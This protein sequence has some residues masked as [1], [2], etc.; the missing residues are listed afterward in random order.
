MRYGHY[1]ILVPHGWMCMGALLAGV[2]CYCRR[3]IET[4]SKAIEYDFTPAQPYYVFYAMQCH[5][6]LE[7]QFGNKGKNI[8]FWPSNVEEVNVSFHRPTGVVQPLDLSQCT[9][10]TIKAS[11]VFI[12]WFRYSKYSV[13]VVHSALD[14]TYSVLDLKWSVDHLSNN[15]DDCLTAMFSTDMFRRSDRYVFN[16]AESEIQSKY[17]LRSVNFTEGNVISEVEKVTGMPIPNLVATLFKGTAPKIRIPL[18]TASFLYRQ[19]SIEGLPMEKGPETQF[20]TQS[21][22]IRPIAMMWERVYNFDKLTAYNVRCEVAAQTLKIKPMSSGEI[23]VVEDDGTE[24][25]LRISGHIFWYFIAQYYKI[26]AINLDSIMSTIRY[27]A[28]MQYSSRK[29]KRYLKLKDQGLIAEVMINDADTHLWHTYQ[30]WVL[31]IETAYYVVNKR[32]PSPRLDEQR[33]LYLKNFELVKG[34]L[35]RASSKVSVLGD[36]SLD[37]VNWR[38]SK[39]NRSLL[40]SSQDK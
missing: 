40:N 5:Y 18:D 21:D 36:V 15:S 32:E 24:Y 9:S 19:C 14:A 13:F 7:D 11:R 38:P 8:A 23:L 28:T 25:P 26:V 17:N 10:A 30:E 16:Y 31:G 3:G 29:M 1:E 33:L 39:D 20:N 12:P 34:L 27:N 6:Q 2:V 4:L 22:I 35:D 37:G